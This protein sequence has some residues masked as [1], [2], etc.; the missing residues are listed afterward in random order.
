MAMFQKL[1]EDLK[2]NDK[3][4]ISLLHEISQHVENENKKEC[5]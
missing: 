5:C 3:E 4:T 2:S 1:I